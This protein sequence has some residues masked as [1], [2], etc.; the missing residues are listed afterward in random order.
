VS[1]ESSCGHRFFTLPVPRRLR[2]PKS[3]L[4]FDLRRAQV[5]DALG[6]D[7]LTPRLGDG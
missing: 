3:F 6:L 7:V 5:G 1:F 4:T 2:Q